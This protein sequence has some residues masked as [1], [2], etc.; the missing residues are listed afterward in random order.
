MNII[1]ILSQIGNWIAEIPNNTIK[2]FQ[3]LGQVL[4]FAD[5]IRSFIVDGINA[6]IPQT[7]AV[8]GTTFL[9]AH[10]ILFATFGMIF[11]VIDIIRDVV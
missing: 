5:D 8:N 2:L 3:A 9:A 11:I 10:V 6:I 1:E 4:G 7:R